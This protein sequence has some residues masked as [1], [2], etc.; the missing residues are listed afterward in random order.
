M[1]HLLIALQAQLHG[2]RIEDGKPLWT[3]K[4]EEAVGKKR[5]RDETEGA[6]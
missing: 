1:Q 6:K 4:M 5:A 2:D 3:A